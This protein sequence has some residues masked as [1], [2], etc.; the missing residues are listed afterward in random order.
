[1]NIHSKLKP[2]IYG[3]IVFAIYLAL[4]FLLKYFTHKTL[5]GDECIGLFST[6]DLLVGVVVALVVTFTH[7]RRKR[8]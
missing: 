8:L 1:M 7:E 3:A 6:N 5:V 4:T 2:L